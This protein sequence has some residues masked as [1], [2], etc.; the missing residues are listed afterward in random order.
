MKQRTYM[1]MPLSKRIARNYCL[2]L[3]GYFLVLVVGVFLAYSFLS[4]FVWYPSDF[5]WPILHWIHDNV[6]LVGACA[7]LFGWL[8]ITIGFE[9]VTLR[10]LHEMVSA[11]RQLASQLEEPI[12]L[13]GAMK[14]IQDELNSV[15]ERTQRNAYLAKEAEQRK[16]DLIV[17]LAHDLK[18]P[19]TSVIGYLT[20]LADEPD[21][22]TELRSRYMGIALD[23]AQRL[24]TLINEFFDIAR[25]NLTSMQLEVTQIDLSMMLEQLAS[26]FLP[27]LREKQLSLKTEIRP[28]VRL[29]CDPDKLERVFDNLLRNAINYSY[30]DSEIRLSMTVD[31]D[32]IIISMTNHGRT[33]AKEKLAHIFEQFYRLDSSRSTSTG[34][35]GL[36]LA[37]AKEIVELHG[38]TITA[39]SENET[40]AFTVTLPLGGAVTNS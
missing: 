26:E 16:N 24:E 25:F 12:V 33:I 10:Y 35:A 14:E 40:I 18:T 4:N 20:L 3:L 34:G 19:L 7:C 28:G 38:G 17:Y 39:E 2:I 37:I 5:L 15:R 31:G 1:D 22:S 23:K 6:V 29:V 27:I 8:V 13:P 21:I 36:G 9:V 11:S 30:P 32:G